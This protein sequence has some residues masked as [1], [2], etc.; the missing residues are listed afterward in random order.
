M[1]GAPILV[2]RDGTILLDLHDPG[3]EAARVRI[4]RFAE[5]VKT[6]EHLHTYRITARSVWTAAVHPDVPGSILPTLEELSGGA[7][8]RELSDHVEELLGRAG[9]IRLERGA[10]GIEVRIAGGLRERLL[11]L[12][13]V[14]ELV[15]SQG[16]TVHLRPGMRGLFKQALLRLGYPVDDVAGFAGGAALSFSLR[17]GAGPGSFRLR[18]YQEAAARAFHAGGTERGGAGVVVLPCGAGKTLVGIRAMHL[19]QTATLILTTNRASVSQWRRELLARTTLREDQVAEYAGS[20]REVAD[21]TV[22]TYQLLIH[23][24]PGLEEFVHFDVF[25]RADWGLIIY[26]EVHLLPAP[27][28]RVTA[29]LQARRR[30]G[31]TATLVRED[32]KE[33]EVYSLIG[34][35]VYE[36]PWRRLEAAGHVA[37]ARCVEVR[38]PLAPAA[39]EEYEESSPRERARIAAE[40]PA[41]L[42]ALADLVAHLSGDRILVIGQYRRQLRE[43]ARRLG[44]PLITGVTPHSER[45]DLYARFRRGDLRLLVVSKV[46]NFAIDLPDAN[47][48]VQISGTF[49]SRQEEAQRLGRILRPKASGGEATFYTLVTAESRDVEFSS[50]RQLFLAEQGYLYEVVH[51]GRGAAAPWEPRS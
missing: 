29:E 30:L 17:T 6:P 27:V 36:L 40:N 34:P 23:R 31:L 12:P 1:N 18:D 10:H 3:A 45:E 7:V 38:I 35:C 49:G 8:P 16:G 5:L 46:A 32:G 22:A 21:V 50:H 15:E 14:Q 39:R 25:R 2:H 47:V 9:R 44:A 20:Q 33:D 4:S 26:D 28:F 42:D 13:S 43:A 51:A 19:F 41:K 37:R 11:G 48:A 24:R